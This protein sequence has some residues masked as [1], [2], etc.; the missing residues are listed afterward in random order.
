MSGLPTEFCEGWP[1]GGGAVPLQWK[2]P[3]FPRRNTDHYYN[4]TTESV[5]VYTHRHMVHLR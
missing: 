1:S 4:E 5:Y 3:L 2:G